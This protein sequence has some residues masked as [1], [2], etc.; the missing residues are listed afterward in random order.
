M[1]PCRGGA[2]GREGARGMDTTARTAGGNHVRLPWL[3]VVVLAPQNSKVNSCGELLSVASPLYKDDD[4]VFLGD[5]RKCAHTLVPRPRHYPDLRASRT[6][7]Y[8]LEKNNKI[9]KIF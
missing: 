3:Q 7:I 4:G 8:I 6:R 9:D 1:A 2:E 5:P